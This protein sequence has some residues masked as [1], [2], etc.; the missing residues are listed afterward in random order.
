MH[1]KIQSNTIK[2]VSLDIYYDE[3]SISSFHR[4]E[5]IKIKTMSIK[6]SNENTQ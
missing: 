1:E 2:Y 6:L 3:S 5:I 4:Y